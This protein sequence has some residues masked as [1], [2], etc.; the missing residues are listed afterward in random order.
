VDL[1]IFAATSI[2][3]EGLRFIPVHPSAWAIPR[4]IGCLGWSGSGPVQDNRMSE[5]TNLVNFD[6]PSTTKCVTGRCGL[7]TV[8]ARYDGCDW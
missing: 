6:R 4:K 1:E 8:G 5:N 3:G 7:R 2:E